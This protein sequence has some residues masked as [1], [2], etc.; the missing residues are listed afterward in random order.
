MFWQM[1]KPEVFLEKATDYTDYT[2]L[3]NSVLKKAAAKQKNFADAIFKK[4]KR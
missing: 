1:T 4:L 2:D 3:K